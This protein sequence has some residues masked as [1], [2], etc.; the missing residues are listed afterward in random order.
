MNVKKYLLSP[1]TDVKTKCSSTGNSIVVLDGVRGLAVLIVLASHTNAFGMFAQGSLGVLL[2][3]FLSGYVLSVPFAKKPE[4]I[5]V[6]GA[7]ERFIINRILRIVPIYLVIAA[8]TALILKTDFKWLVWNISLIKGWNHFWSVAQEARFYILFPFVLAILAKVRNDYLRLV[9]LLGFV[10]FSFRYRGIHTI[11]MMDGRNVEFYFYMFLGGCLT[12]FLVESCSTTRWMHNEYVKRAFTFTNVLIFLFIF[13]SSSYMIKYFWRP[14][15]PF[16]PSNFVMNGW[17]IPNVWLILFTIFFFSLVSYREGLV[18]NILT[19]FFFRHIGLLS[20]SIYL[21]HMILML[22]LRKIG[23]AREG[24]FIAVFST[25]YIVALVSY[26][27]VEKPFL[28]LKGKI[29]LPRRVA[30]PEKRLT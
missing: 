16:L 11:D 3:F 25:S 6:S 28:L 12:C 24:L 15:F 2:F 23:L 30:Q 9:I 5:L 19:G 8:V 27:T 14:L 7:I 17:G 4:K 10:V 22:K 1:F 13:F 29:H 26:V 21:V 18:Y 20:Y